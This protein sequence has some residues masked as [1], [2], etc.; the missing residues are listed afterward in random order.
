[1]S[2]FGFN[3]QPYKKQL[4][5]LVQ[6]IEDLPGP[7]WKTL[8]KLLRKYPKDGRDIFSRDQIIKGYRMLVNEGIVVFNQDFV[9]KVKMKPVRTISGVTPVT[10]LTKPY[11][12]PG[13]CIYC[14][15]DV[16]MPKSYLAMEPG[17]Q[18]A[19][20][21]AFDPYLQTYNRLEAFANIGHR[22]DKV[23]LIILGG[24]WSFYPVK[25]QIWF[26]KRCFDALNDFGVRDNRAQVKTNNIFAA[27]DRR[28]K[29]NKQGRRMTYNEIIS[30]VAY[31]KSRGFFSPEELS[32]W[33]ALLA[34]QIQNE[35]AA[36]RCVGLVIETRPDYLTPEEIVKIRKLGATKV[37]IGIQSLDDRVQQLNKRGHGRK[38]VEQAVSLLR[39]AGFKI[40][41]HWMPNL[42]GSTPKKDKKDY[43]RLWEQSIRPDELKIYPTSIIA[44]TELFELYK[45]GKYHPY[46][47]TELTEVLKFCFRHTPRYC[48]L[49]RVIRDIPAHDIVAGNKQSNLRQV[50]EAQLLDSGRQCQC[51]RCREI[52]NMMVRFPDLELEKIIYKTSTGKEIFLSYKAKKADKIVGFLRLHLPWRSLS[53]KHFI[54]ELADCAIIREV[55]VYGQV[56]DLGEK[57]SRKSQHLGIGTALIN[58]ARL[59]SKAYKFSKLAVISAIGTREYYRK[60]GFALN[61]LYMIAE[62]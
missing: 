1:M 60:R 26:V 9:E 22:V 2:S 47:E 7:S 52:R 14:P 30:K 37:Q 31:G 18:R 29:I 50:A 3:P 33:P 21:N 25:Y 61:D 41:A 27:A 5:Q 53:R 51:I 38:E 17:A 24:T 32:D 23:E 42:L 59:L 16:R 43:L 34:A 4:L 56:A 55:H 48:R 13:K 8:Q 19:E 54:P 49:T 45:K 62:I 10:V 58:K 35:T 6:D 40:H 20:R 28:E 46:T 36:S 39:L 15:N 11:P 44:D 57:N 12:C